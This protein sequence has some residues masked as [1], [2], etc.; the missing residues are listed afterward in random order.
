MEVMMKFNF[1]EKRAFVLT[2][3]VLIFFCLSIVMVGKRNLWFETKNIYK[4]VVPD[5]DG[6]SVGNQINFLG[7]KVGEVT[8]LNI[9]QENKIEVEFSVKKSLA[10]KIKVDS[11]ARMNR[12]FGIGEVRIEIVPG[13]FDSAILVNGGILKG[14]ESTEITD[15]ISGKNIGVLMDS[16][17]GIS[18]GVGKWSKALE[19]LNAKFKP[20]DIAESYSLI[21]PVMKN[22]EKI[23]KDLNVFIQVLTSLKKD[24]LDNKL[25]KKSLIHFD[26]L[27]A[28]LSARHREIE[29]MVLDIGSLSKGLAKNPDFATDITKALKEVIITLKAMQKSYF[30]ESHVKEI[31][32]SKK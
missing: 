27:M 10:Y 29:G 8:A 12:A 28:P 20:E 22:V 6:L 4:T 1:M 17:K 3:G 5:A 9:N 26:R 2:I 14:K 32:K 16:I 21:L 11:L 15:L 24:M 7:L 31:K 19:L 23:T 25:A 18:T 13:T 30:L